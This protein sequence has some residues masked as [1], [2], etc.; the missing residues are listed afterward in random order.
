MITL[1][2]APTAKPQTETELARTVEKLL[3]EHAEILRLRDEQRD[4]AEERRSQ[5]AK[6]EADFSGDLTPQL[7]VDG[8][9]QLQAQVEIAEQGAALLD[10]RATA[11]LTEYQVRELEVELARMRSEA[12]AQRARKQASQELK[13]IQAELPTRVEQLRRSIL[14][15][16]ALE[17]RIRE[18]HARIPQLGGSTVGVGKLAQEASTAARLTIIR[19]PGSL[20][21]FLPPL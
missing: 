9:R 10:R 12:A 20:S 7:L 1:T 15:T 6:L 11:F 3:A 14:A 19:Q 18:L 2:D 8:Q 5:I 13:A 4:A 21:G 16:E 17:R